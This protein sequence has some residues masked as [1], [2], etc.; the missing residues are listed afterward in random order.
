MDDI[1]MIR[2]D[3]KLAIELDY[4]VCKKNKVDWKQGYNRLCMLSGS[5]PI[6]QG[7]R[8]D[9]EYY[10]LVNKPKFQYY[11]LKGD[12]VVGR[13]ILA[14]R[15][16]NFINIQYVSI[17]NE[18]RGKGYGIRF[19]QMLEDEIMKDDNVLGII[20]ED[21]SHLGQISRIANKLGYELNT[22]GQFIKY[23]PD[24]DKNIA[25]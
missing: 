17:E 21:V 25:L 2:P 9:Q 23:R 14:E 15:A 8:T 5:E 20:M 18:Y 12:N 10:K 24:K 1:V 13:A 19:V 7:N 3:K 22:N 4:L 16:N 11:L 6:L